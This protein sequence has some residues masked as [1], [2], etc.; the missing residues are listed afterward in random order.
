M[1]SRIWNQS[2]TRPAR[3]YFT[4][5]FY[6]SS[7]L[8]FAFPVGLWLMPREKSRPFLTIIYGIT[9]RLLSG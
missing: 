5:S 8:L 6:A 4:T 9:S 3:F 1:D 7:Y 2:F